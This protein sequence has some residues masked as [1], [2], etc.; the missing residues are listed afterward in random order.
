MSSSPTG[1]GLVGAV[2][3]IA[4]LRAAETARNLG[5]HRAENMAQQR[6][7]ERYH[8]V[9]GDEGELHI[10]LREL[11]L[12]VGAQILVPEALGDLAVPIESAAIRSCLK[13]CG[14]WGSA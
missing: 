6:L 4:R 11:G 14:D 1:V 5:Q 8:A 2:Y 13:S 10:D 7:V 12:A 9:P 3:A